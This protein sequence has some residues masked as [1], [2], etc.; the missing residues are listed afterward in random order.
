[1]TGFNPD[2][3]I[4][5]LI[6]LILLSAFFSG[7]E[8]GMMALNRYRLRHLARKGDP[9]AK[10]TAKLLE[11]PDRLLGII[12]LGNTFANV[13]ASAV[14]TIIAVHY[15]G[16]LG[17]LISTIALTFVLLIFAETT[18]KTL[19]ALCPQRVA[20]PA[21][22]PLKILLVILYPLVWFINGVANGVLR[23]F[24]IKVKGHMIEPLTAEELR[25]VVREASGKISSNYQQILLRVLNL[26]Q[27]TV[28]DV[29]VPRNEIYGIDITDDWDKI[30]KQLTESEH[31]KIPIYRENIDQVIGMLNLRSLIGQLPKR[32][33]T[34]DRLVKLAKEVYFIPEVTLINRQLLNFQKENRRIGLVIDEYG[35]IQGL[36]S[37]QDIIEEIVGEF[38][39]DIDDVARLVQRQEDGSYLVDGRISLRDLNRLTDWELPIEGPKTLSGLVIEHLEMIP[40]SGM[41]L[42]LVGYPMEVIKVSGNTIRLVKVW[43]EKRVSS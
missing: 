36:V 33:L 22:L 39:I 29:M 28:E 3:L 31:T 19:A 18:P 9:A 40:T 35:D 12:L 7:S 24:R 1:M 15:L 11:R 41:A 38:A 4:I 20:F 13:F 21:S 30:L 25:S 34:K 23:L 43:P 5:L 14:A 42:R 26:G 27:I 6:L 16:D 17:V 2:L 10:R 32:E 8:T 37:I